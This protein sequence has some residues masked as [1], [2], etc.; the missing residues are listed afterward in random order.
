MASTGKRMT[1]KRKSAWLITWG[2]STPD[3]LERFG[4]RHVIA[5]LDARKSRRQ[6]REYC[7][8]LFHA[9]RGMTLSE[10]LGDAKLDRCRWQWH[11]D[12][13]HGSSNPYIR[14]RLVSDLSVEQ[15]DRH[16]Q[17][18]RFTERAADHDR[19]AEA[20]LLSP[21]QPAIIRQHY[22]RGLITQ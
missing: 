5:I 2:A 13:L 22:D 12:V 9:T 1:K 14:A 7:A 4:T 17:V 6:I 20:E 16:H 10:Q 11:G 15:P 8:V 18:L 21:N 19:E 3:R